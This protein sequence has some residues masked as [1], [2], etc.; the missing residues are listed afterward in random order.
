M[1]AI[2]HSHRGELTFGGVL[3]LLVLF[4]LIVAVAHALDSNKR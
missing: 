4:T 2:L 3:L 1:I